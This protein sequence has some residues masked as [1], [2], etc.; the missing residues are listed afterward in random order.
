MVAPARQ[1][2][3]PSSVLT[4]AYSPSPSTHDMIPMVMTIPT[5]TSP[6]HS[7]LTEQPPNRD[8]PR[9]NHVVPV[10]DNASHVSQGPA[11]R[12]LRCLLPSSSLTPDAASA[13]FTTLRAR[14]NVS[15]PVTQHT[16][17]GETNATSTV[18]SHCEHWSRGPPSSLAPR[19]HR[20]SMLPISVTCATSSAPAHG[21]DASELCKSEALRPIT[22]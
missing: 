5:P 9:M 8:S 1:L 12:T 17:T 18:V 2:E 21:R 3:C 11:R 7:L 22:R 15:G 16:H 13:A 20:S 4:P 19:C 14:R 6:A 10:V